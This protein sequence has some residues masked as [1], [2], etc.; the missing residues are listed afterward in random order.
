MKQS[1]MIALGA[2]V[3]TIVGTGAFF[4]TAE[5]AYACSGG[6]SGGGSYE[7]SWEWVFSN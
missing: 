7:F 3:A 1:R 5:P 4:A 6:G 2:L